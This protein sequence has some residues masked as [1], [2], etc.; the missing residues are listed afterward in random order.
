ME[1]EDGNERRTTEE[2]EGGDEQQIAEGPLG[3]PVSSV[4]WRVSGSR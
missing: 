3:V 4:S 2:D 1:R